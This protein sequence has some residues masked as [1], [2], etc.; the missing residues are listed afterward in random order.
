MAHALLVFGCGDGTTSGADKTVEEI[1][2]E[3]TD[4]EK[5]EGKV[6]SLFDAKKQGAEE[7]VEKDTKGMTVEEIFLAAM[8]RNEENRQR[9]SKERSKTN[10]SVLRSYRI[11]NP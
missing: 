5:T 1:L 11:K 6:I 4:T 8:R 9:L 7:S 2:M 10:K 3:R